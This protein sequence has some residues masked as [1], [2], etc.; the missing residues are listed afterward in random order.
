[1]KSTENSIKSKK[2]W[3][4]ILPVIAWHILYLIFCNSFD[5][6][7]RVYFDLVFYFVIACYFFFLRDWRFSEW[8]NALKKGKSF[9]LPV[10][11]TVFGMVAAFGAG[12]GIM[13]LFPGAND[14]MSVFG[15]NSMGTLI[16]FAF[17]TIVLPPIAEEAFYR[18]AVTAFDTKTIL[19]I[20]TIVSIFLYAS[21]HSL[22]PLGFLQACLWA[23]PFNIAYIKTRNIYVCMTAHFLCNFAFNGM[24]V[25][26]SAIGLSRM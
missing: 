13:L 5:K 3:F 2:Y 26:N 10:L 4:K 21:E 19:V 25:I 24:T 8:G 14:G 18:K 20:S 6:F 12:F 1:M 22:M 23:I 9:W 16:A 7:T 17:A 15:I 11:Y